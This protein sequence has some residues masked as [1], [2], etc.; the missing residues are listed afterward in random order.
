MLAALPS[1]GLTGQCASKSNINQHSV[2][3]Y[4]S[5]RC[6]KECRG[7]FQLGTELANWTEILFRYFSMSVPEI[8]VPLQDTSFSDYL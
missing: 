4:K 2:Q 7:D 5:C 8:L 6:P 1:C 3:V